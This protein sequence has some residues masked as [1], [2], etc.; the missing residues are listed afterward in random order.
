[1]IRYVLPFAFLHSMRTSITPSPY[2]PQQLESFVEP[3]PRQFSQL[4]VIFEFFEQSKMDTTEL[5]NDEGAA[6]WK[7]ELSDEED[8]EGAPG[9][10]VANEEEAEES[11]NEARA[12]DSTPPTSYFTQLS[13]TFF[14]KVDVLSVL[15]A[16]LFTKGFCSSFEAKCHIMDVMFLCA[17]ARSHGDR[18]GDVGLCPVVER[19]IAQKTSVNCPDGVE[20]LRPV[21]ITRDILTVFQRCYD[22]T[23]LANACASMLSIAASG[24]LVAPKAKSSAP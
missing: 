11:D 20:Q 24:T 5:L 4:V 16:W 1:M 15:A 23:S 7:I 9:D 17:V 14:W 2:R 10:T 3:L 13:T 19:S 6:D 18:N 22:A 21:S 12:T 8:A